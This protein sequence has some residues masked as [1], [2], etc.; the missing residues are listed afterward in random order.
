[1]KEPNE[2]TGVQKQLC[3]I[4][5]R[6]FFYTINFWEEVFFLARNMRTIIKVRGFSFHW[7]KYRNT[8]NIENA[9][10]YLY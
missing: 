9:F 4:L 10:S 2:F 8:L 7:G 1:M 6:N 5:T 3:Q